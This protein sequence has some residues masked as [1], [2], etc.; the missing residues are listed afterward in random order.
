[1]TAD[2]C[3][4]YIIERGRYLQRVADP[5]R[6]LTLN[7]LKPRQNS[8]HF[9]DDIFERI[10]LNK[11]VW[12]SINIPLKF[13]HRGQMNTN[14]ASVQV[15]SWCRTCRQQAITWTIGDP[16]SVHICIMRPQCVKQLGPFYINGNLMSSVVH[17]KCNIFERNGFKTVIICL[18]LKLTHRGRDK[19]DAISQTTFSSTFSWMKTFEFRLKFHWSLFLRVELTIF[20]HWFR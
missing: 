1:M 8:S 12:I 11:N 14:S 10:F 13:L 6:L 15:M 18:A 3:G 9:A 4:S 17:C 20:Q 2:F 16:A 19:M 5:D 7:T